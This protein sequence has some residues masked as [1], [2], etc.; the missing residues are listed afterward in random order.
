[1]LLYGYERFCARNSMMEPSFLRGFIMKRMSFCL[2]CVFILSGCTVHKQLI[3]MGGS[4]ADG[5]IR[6]GY[7]V[8]DTYGM[9]EK[10]S[11]DMM[12]AQSLAIQKCKVWGYEGAEA[13][14]GQSSQCTDPSPAGCRQADIYV[15]Y[16]CTGGK[17]SQN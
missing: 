16:Q 5:T 6:M 3:P 13:F 9:F 7:H 15:E 1:M 11:V 2:L 8:G 17:A 10:A 4:K 12:Q 14:G